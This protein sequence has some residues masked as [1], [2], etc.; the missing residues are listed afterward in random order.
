MPLYSNLPVK[1]ISETRQ[2]FEDYFKSESAVSGN[3][4]DAA[5]A[6]FEKQATSRAAAETIAAALL[7]AVKNQGL[8]AGEILDQFKTLN[9]DDVNRY[10]ITVLNSTR[11]ST[12]F[13]G[14]RNPQ[15]NNLFV[16]RT[17]LP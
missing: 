1:E 15:R 12:S 2:Y 4:Y 14:F 17:I 11:K 9:K 7:E 6:L 8:D 16:S 3:L 5:V 10:M 13:L